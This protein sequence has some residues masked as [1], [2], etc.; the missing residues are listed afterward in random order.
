MSIEINLLPETE[1][2]FP[3]HI[4]NIDEYK[5][6]SDV[7]DKK[8]RLVWEAIDKITLNQHF[9]LMDESECSR[10]EKILGIRIDGDETIEDRRRAIKGNWASSIPYTEKRFR[11]VLNAMLGD[12]NYTLTINAEKK[13][14]KVDIKLAAIL[15]YEYIADL[16]R[17]MA[18]ADMVVSVRIMYNRWS[19]FAGMTWGDLVNETWESLYSDEKWQEGST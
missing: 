11:D 6:I 14:L 12:D 8:L 7:Y 4:K 10:W 16:M 13:T 19:R 3:P 1:H 17:K 15:K 18:P 5:R 9:D 2:Y